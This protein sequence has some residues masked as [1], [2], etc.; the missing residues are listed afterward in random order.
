MRPIRRSPKEIDTIIS[1]LLTGKPGAKQD[2]I[3][4]LIPETASMDERALAQKLEYLKQRLR[5]DASGLS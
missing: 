5:T 3:R 2:E 1:R 4:R